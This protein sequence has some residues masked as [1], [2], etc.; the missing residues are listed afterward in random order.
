MAAGQRS[1]RARVAGE[2]WLDRVAIEL[3]GLE[4]LDRGRF[5]QQARVWVQTASQQVLAEYTDAIGLDLGTS[6]SVVSLY[7]KQQDTPEVV[8]QQRRRQIP[9]VFAIDRSG[10]ELVGV[11][12]SELLSKSPRA[13]ITK[14][15]REMGTDRKFRA[16]GQDYRA[17]EISARIINYARQFA[18][19][20]LKQKIAVKLSTLASQTLGSSPPADWV[21]EFLEQHPPT[22]PLSKIVITVPAYFNEAQKQATKTAGTL[23]DT[24]VLRLIHEPTAAC[25]AQRILDRKAETILVADLGA[26]TFDLSV[27]Q[28]GDGVFEV[29]EIEGDNT[30]GSAD[31]DEL[32]YTHFSDLIKAETGQD[33]PRNSQAATRLRQACE[34]LKI[35]LSS[36]HEWTIDLLYLIGDRTIQLALTRDELERLASSWLDKIQLTCRKI[37]HQPDRILL[38]GGGGQMPAVRRC[39][40]A[41]FHREPDSAYDPLT[42]VARGAALQGAILLGDVQGTL[43]LDV[44]PFSLGIKCRVAPGEFKF[45]SVI[46]KHTTIPTDRTQRYTTTED[47]QTQVR[48]E[49]FQG[50]S[51][52]PEENFKIGEFILQGIPIAKAGV[53]QIDVKF[54]I[55]SNCL[56]MVTARDVST[57]NQQSIT[58]ADSHLLTPAQTTSLQAQFRNSQ[59]YQES[60]ASLEKLTAVLKATL[61]EVENTNLS[62][63]SIRFKTEFRPMNDIG[64]AIYPHPPT[65]L[66]CL[67]S[68]AIAIN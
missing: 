64:N 66:S 53:P 37:R 55:D 56:L 39:I 1:G 22:I 16:G 31:L 7:N 34:E 11:P 21:N 60:L 51:S 14:A 2:K 41:V 47:N 4:R 27:I 59:L 6:N 33:I 17:E 19:E 61:Q 43:L 46:P 10:R 35:E 32:I 3:P 62:E 68:I 63:L 45:D 15:K 23:A 49:I 38:I 52:V 48:I 28:A 5:E 40:Q 24:Q 26:G 65:T 58:I 67:K 12:I 9:S 42:V 36:Q 57:G 44:A 50:E 13:I 8:E 20:Y 25:L 29:E 18:R 30:L 54:N